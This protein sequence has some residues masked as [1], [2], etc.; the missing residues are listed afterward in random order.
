[1]DSSNEKGAATGVAYLIRHLVLHSQQ[2]NTDDRDASND[3]LLLETTILALEDLKERVHDDQVAIVTTAKELVENLAR[4][5]DN[6]GNVCEAQLNLLLNE[7]TE[8][9]SKRVVPLEIKAQNAALIITRSDKYVTFEALELSPTNEAAQQKGRLIRHFP[10][11]TVSLLASQMR[12][13][14]FTDSLARTLAKLTTQEA[15]GHQPQVTKASCNHNEPRDTANPAMVTDWFMHMLTAVGKPKDATSITKHTREEV[16]WQKQQPWR[17]SPLWLL[18]RVSLQLFFTRHNEEQ[19]SPAELYKAFSILIFSRVIQKAVEG[20]YWRYFGSE[21]LHLTSQKLLRRMLKFERSNLGRHLCQ[22][23]ENTVKVTIRSADEFMVEQ[24]ANVE[25]SAEKNIGTASHS[26][27][28]EENQDMVL[29]A[30][31]ATLI[32]TKSRQQRATFRNFWPPNPLPSLPEGANDIPNLPDQP[33]EPIEY[34]DYRL[35]KLEHWVQEQS[36]AWIISRKHETK[37][38][39]KLRQLMIAYHSK[40]SVRYSG[41]PTAMSIMYLTLAELWVMC[42]KTVCDLHPLLKEYDPKICIEE[43][44]NLCL[45]TKN[46]MG[47]LRA[48]ENYVAERR[49]NADLSLP[50]I[51]KDFG[52]PSSLAVRLFEES[53]NLQHVK[54][55]IEDVATLKRQKKCQELDELKTQYQDMMRRHDK[56][57]CECELATSTS[58]NSGFWIFSTCTCVDCEAETFSENNAICPRCQLKI[59]A[60]ALECDVFEWPLPPSPNEANAV[61]FELNPLNSVTEWRDASLHF[62]TKVL[63]FGYETPQSPHHI[64]TFTSRKDLLPYLKKEQNKGQRII[65]LSEIKG[66]TETLYRKMLSVVNI[67]YDD[68]CLGNA[69]DYKYFDRTERKW[70]GTFESSEQLPL[71]AIYTLPQR[72][73]TLSRY[74]FRPHSAPDGL[75]CNETVAN[76]TD[77]PTQFS[78]EEYRAFTSVSL[79]RNI[80]Y[81]N[82]LAQL[83]MPTLDFTK[84]ET[85]VLIL[86]AIHQVGPGTVHDERVNHHILT[87]YAF[88]NVMITKLEE[89]LGLVD[90]NGESWRALTV[91]TQLVRRTLSLTPHLNI[92]NRCL[93]YLDKVRKISM[94]WLQHI[95]I[96]IASTTDGEHRAILDT[97]A[98]DIALLCTSTFDIENAFL[99]N[100]FRQSS[101]VSKLIRCSIIIQ[102]ISESAKPEFESMHKIMVQNWRAL[103]C[104]VF[105]QLLSHTLGCNKALN[106][107]ISASWPAFRPTPGSGSSWKTFSNIHPDWLYINS[108]SL[109]VHFNLL[110]SELLVN[111]LPLESIP[112]EFTAHKMFPRLFKKSILAVEPSREPGMR[113]SALNLYHGHKLHF[114]MS[115]ENMMVL[116]INDQERLDLI[117]P[118]IFDDH[119]P[120][121]YAK[122]YVHW[123]DH[124]HDQVIFRPCERPWTSNDDEWR[125]LHINGKWRLA[126]ETSILLNRLG[127]NACAISKV[128]ESL[129]DEKYIYATKNTHPSLLALEISLPRLQL[130]FY[131]MQDDHRI[132]S[133]QYRGMFVDDD[134][135]IGTLVGF[136]SKLVLRNAKDGR[137]VL[138][139]KQR[140]SSNACSIKYTKDTR[141]HH[142][143]VIIDKEKVDTVF[144]YSLDPILGRILDNGDMQA[145]LLLCY[146]H[147]LTSNCIPDSFTH[148]TGTESALL[149]LKSAAIHSFELLTAENIALLTLI[150]KLSPIRK[151][152]PP[153]ESVIQQVG[154]DQHLPSQSQ[155]PEFAGA[156]HEILDEAKRMQPFY[157]RHTFR[158]PRKLEDWK[159][160]HQFLEKR[161]TIRSAIFHCSE[162]GAENYTSSHDTIYEARDIIVAS[163][164]GERSF[165]A[166]T[167]ILQDDFE[168]RTPVIHL[169]IPLMSGDFMTKGIGENIDIPNLSFDT[170]WLHESASVLAQYWCRIHHHFST[171][172]ARFNKYD[173]MIWL[174]T[175]AYATSANMDA[176]QTLGA[177]YKLPSLALVPV[178][179]FSEINISLG[180]T[181]NPEQLTKL[182]S[183]AA[184]D[185]SMCPEG[186][187]RK[188]AKELNST[189]ARRTITRYKKGLNNAINQLV[190]ELEHQWHKKHPKFPLSE[191]ITSYLDINL[192][193]THVLSRFTQWRL[194][195]RFGDYVSGI[196]SL[197]ASQTVVPKSSPP[198]ID[199]QSNGLKKLDD[200]AR[201]ISTTA[202]FHTPAPAI[203]SSTELIISGQENFLQPTEPK[204]SITER[205]MDTR[206]ISR[207]K[208]LKNLCAKLRMLV[209]CRT[210]FEKAYVASL[211]ASRTTLERQQAKPRVRDTETHKNTK[212]CSKE[213][214]RDLEA[215]LKDCEIHV[216]ALHASMVEAIVGNLNTSKGFVSQL[217]QSHPL[218]PIFW[219]KHL[220]R[221]LFDTLSEDWKRMIIKYGLAITRLHRAHRLVATFDN[222]AELVEELK[223]NGHNNWDPY[224][225]PE[226]L[227]FE[228]D[229]CILVRD[230]QET[231]AGH[232]RSPEGNVNTVMQLNMGEGKSSTIIP[233]VAA[234]LA[235]KSRLVR[236]I[237][238][239]SQYQQMSQTFVSKLGGLLNR[240]LYHMPFSREL[241]LSASNAPIIQNIWQNCMDNGGI[242]LVQPEHILSYR[243]MGINCLLTNSNNNTAEAFLKGQR[244]LDEFSSDLIDETDEQFDPKSELA[245]TV[246]TQRSVEFAPQRWH[247]IQ[248]VFN[249]LP[250]IAD[251]VKKWHPLSIEV[252][253]DADWRFPR[254]RVLD[255]RAAKK[256][257]EE[258]AKEIIYSELIPRASSL[259]LQ[260][261]VFEYI[262]VPELSQEQVTLVEDSSFWVDS[263]KETILIIRGLIAG[264]ILKF[265]L[266]SKRWRVNFGL[267]PTRTPPTKLAVPFRFKDS[268]ALK[269][270]FSH[271]EVLI[272]LTLLSYYY[273]GLSDQNMFDTFEFL[274]RSGHATEEYNEWVASASP[275]LPAAFRHLSGIAFKDKFLCIT[276]V[277]P[278]LRYSKPCIDYFLSH[279][280]FPKEVREFE[281]K[282]CASSWDL[283]MVKTYPTVGFSGTIDM[284][285]LLPLSVKHLHLDCQAHTNAEV[286][287]KLLE[288]DRTSVELLPP[289]GVSTDADYLLMAV[290]N[291]DPEIRVV[292][293]CGAII[294]EQSNQQ[295]AETWLNLSSRDRIQAAVFFNGEEL[296]ILERTGRVESFQVSPFAQQLDVCIVYLDESHTRGID[297]KLPQDYRAGVTLG[298]ALTKDKLIQGCMRMRKLGRN[299][300]IAFILPEEIA[301]KVCD[302]TG[303]ERDE[304]EAAD[305]LLY[306]ISET[307]SDLK[308]H[309]PLWA[310]Q[311][312]RYETTKHLHNGEN[313]TKTE[314]EGFLEPEAQ[315]L[316][317]RYRPMVQDLDGQARLN[318]WDKSN[319]NI[320]QMVKKCEDSGTMGFFVENVDEMDEEQERELA[321]EKEEECQAE[322]PPKIEAAKHKIHRDLDTLVKEGVIKQGSF[323]PA[324]QAL[325]QTRAAKLID[326]TQFPSELLVTQDF[327]HTIKTPT[328]SKKES[329]LSDSYLRSVEWIISVPSPVDAKVIQHLVIVSPHEA[330]HV[331]HMIKGYDKV[332]LHVYRPRTNTDFDPLDKLDL[333]NTGR[334]FDPAS[335]SSSLRTQLNL[336]AG[337]LYLDSYQE[338]TDLCDFLGLLRLSTP[339][340]GQ[341]VQVDG[342]LVPPL[343]EWG[344]L[345]SPIP[346][347]RALLLGIRGEGDGRDK[348]HL[349][350]ILRGIKMEEAD[351]R[352]DVQ[353]GGV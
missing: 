50:S 200:M 227:L 240:R 255:T 64:Y 297:L 328:I 9:A 135:T 181:W 271:P 54:T 334:D 62:M 279:L 175:M 182:L 93:N 59:D 6:D 25:A 245:Y 101:T 256:L 154:W 353:M 99:E 215:Y 17:R 251:R 199:N 312:H 35:A 282:L 66:H 261:A 195:R 55:Q 281:S 83:A 232:M 247:V 201:Y 333:Y 170:I 70:C 8:T 243:L 36:A 331:R 189:H 43:F 105:P 349:G 223:N 132:Y 156:V 44:Q 72:S 315:T 176:V 172:A 52:H 155:R 168:L 206:S 248:T 152:Y 145:K 161:D 347:L 37:T 235:N 301:T 119:I 4:S 265:I 49:N 150:A 81:Q 239:K 257:L 27:N 226:T 65:L 102:K 104:R 58:S 134:Q 73:T 190:V 238:G 316:E 103:S 337:S 283:G 85:L 186:N 326:L 292:L 68:V 266:N 165:Q 89:V 116:A 7:I 277:F 322:R 84:V 122:D 340:E 41:I 317:K 320:T 153:F 169:K 77:C 305:V 269:S 67:E 272:I 107:A 321:P 287:D 33:P 51:Y 45:P 249:L 112:A 311:G 198:F 310:M 343:G 296:S 244:W 2:P 348:T 318:S 148:H 23:W 222:S 117:S 339:E 11:R 230:I 210:A 267:H 139:P 61:V 350:K 280:V 159:S 306:S 224:D 290:T 345:K 162:F 220:N 264:G 114:G 204:I 76:T 178:P 327:I 124:A 260:N 300:S 332:T 42:D 275:T 229:N 106:D 53:S 133:R 143:K 197:M 274:L 171:S 22:G 217:Q 194:N 113:F 323:I 346:F 1:M 82:I 207:G 90:Q 125:L 241:H 276:H 19:E 94:S 78:I 24:W 341:D 242:M 140:K 97:R 291:M 149:I 208:E 273:E 205:P 324:F 173:V 335:V 157:P 298:A 278:H 3:N 325:A 185:I 110:T 219:L 164:A 57:T 336:F 254:V 191:E 304:I 142:V 307:L 34:T 109:R 158:D 12:D 121:A 131:I 16:F 71:E 233:I 46:Q 284:Q 192:A 237:V 80:V 183:I 288:D 137:Q 253:R 299:Q 111:G 166:A 14:G 174:S 130:N 259:E 209:K 146:L 319:E 352:K 177:M 211:S 184:K 270:D 56:G 79:G 342:F 21:S 258:L 308:R 179:E 196:S 29:S 28:L 262:T 295:V 100:V 95:K 314:A 213:C 294:L 151:F 136:S 40:A 286:L 108:N 160:S 75:P 31:D 96:S 330:N 15:L 47:R 38:C 87:E 309:T 91:Y 329:Y 285:N 221:K 216:E 338:Y 60:E 188:K 193:K 236:V 88:G 18:I 187:I 39:K 250:E 86:Q 293:D 128:F 10:S 123:Y 144:V 126:K 141:H 252:Q 218:S 129:G 30:L 163:E 48:V 246:G 118:E 212:K 268:P 225:F 20:S 228:V 351:F 138:I 203:S 180:A 344:L 263:V 74:L 313:T 303:N 302:Q 98:M 69:F 127:H 147:A 26:L 115:G 231:I 92:Q 214:L 32:S 202:M 289:R 63:R 13:E 5:R 167:M 234:T 120:H